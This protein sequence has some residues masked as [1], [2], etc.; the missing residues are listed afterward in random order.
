MNVG[1]NNHGIK[2]IIDQSHLLNVFFVVV[3]ARYE[4]RMGHSI[5]E[6]NYAYFI[7]Q[8]INKDAF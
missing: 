2:K 1:A 3:A 5:E 8:S 7:E 4:V 6:G